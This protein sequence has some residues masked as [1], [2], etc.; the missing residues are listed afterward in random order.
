[1]ESLYRNLEDAGFL[2]KSQL[3]LI[4]E[5]F[6]SEEDMY[7]KEGPFSETWR[8]YDRSEL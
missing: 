1:M 7:N 8:K 6:L 2:V 3:A 5:L 4:S